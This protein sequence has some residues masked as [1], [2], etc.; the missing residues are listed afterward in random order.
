MPGKT[1]G[2]CGQTLPACLPPA[3]WRESPQ[4]CARRACAAAPPHQQNRDK[5][6]P[7]PRAARA[8]PQKRPQRGTGVGGVG[9]RQTHRGL[10]APPQN[11][12]HLWQ[13][14]FSLPPPNDRLSAKPA[15]HLN[16][17]FELSV[18][19]SR[20]GRR[21]PFALLEDT[22]AHAVGPRAKPPAPK[23]A[24]SAP[25]AVGTPLRSLHHSRAAPPTLR[26]ARRTGWQAR[27]H[28][29]SPQA[30]S[31]GRVQHSSLTRGPG[32]P[33]RHHLP[34]PTRAPQGPAPHSPGACPARRAALTSA[35]TGLQLRNE[36]EQRRCRPL[37]R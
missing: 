4:Q 11:G 31:G 9:G 22:E 37:Y 10:Q 13:G 29:A 1:P 6:A 14:L 16:P 25:H 36:G 35:H 34:R 21:P 27:F 33:P 23:M 26:G 17:H 3:Q 15:T 8:G 24:A 12:G 19:P 2:A 20:R 5:A 30:R 28:R 32:P 7:P 18:R